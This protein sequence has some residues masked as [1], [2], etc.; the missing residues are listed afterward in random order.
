MKPV[1][2]N[3]ELIEYIF[4][5]KVAQNH[6]ELLPIEDANISADV[7]LQTWPNTAGGFDQGGFSGQAFTT[8]YTTV[9]TEVFSIHEGNDVKY[10]FAFGV[11]FGNKMA[12]MLTNPN[13][14]FYEDLEK[15]EIK[16]IKNAT[17]YAESE[18]KV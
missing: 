8:Q 13:E 9:M 11:F 5:E 2:P 16:S 3:L 12:Y 10:T 4:K 18:E 14:S 7:F 17:K 1:Y 15:R 6:P